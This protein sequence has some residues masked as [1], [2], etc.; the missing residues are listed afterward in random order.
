MLHNGHP[1]VVTMLAY[2]N[3]VAAMDWL[4]RAFGFVERARMI[5][6]SGR[7]SHG[8]LRT[9]NG[10]VMLATPTPEYAGPKGHRDH[11]RTPSGITW[12]TNGLLVYVD[13]VEAHFARAQ[14]AGARVLGPIEDGFPGRRYRAE[15]LEGQRWMFLQRQ[16]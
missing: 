15:D 1:D 11:A 10:L 4:I 6:G 8:E 7:L 13:D 2:A 3:G 5:D 9:G 14:A 16:T 12:V